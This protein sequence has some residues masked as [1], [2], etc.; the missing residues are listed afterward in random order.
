MIKKEMKSFL[1]L[2]IFIIERETTLEV[3][4]EITIL[5]MTEVG[6]ELQLWGVELQVG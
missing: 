5:S 6:A 2:G 1:N 3:Q 4:I